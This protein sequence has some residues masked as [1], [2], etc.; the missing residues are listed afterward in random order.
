MDVGPHALHRIVS[1]IVAG[2][3]ERATASRAGRIGNLKPSNVLIGGRGDLAGADILLADPAAAS[4]AASMGEAGDRLSLGDVIHQLVLGRRFDDGTIWPLPPDPSWERLGD[5]GERW[6]RLCNDLL[7]PTPRPVAANVRSLA[8]VVQS[9]APRRRR[10]LLPAAAAALLLAVTVV[11]AYGYAGYR[12][13]RAYCEAK[14]QWLGA[15]A[16]AAADPA[17]RELYAR[18]AN[19]KK[20]LAELDRVPPASVDCHGKGGLPLSFTAF[21]RTRAAAASLATIT[22]ALS[23]EQWPALA[24]AASAQRRFR[25]RGWDQPA[26]YLARLVEGVRP[27]RSED[28][29]GGIDRFVLISDLEQTLGGIESDWKIVDEAQKTLAAS[30]VD[31]L[32]AFGR[33]LKADS[34]GAL[35][36]TAVGFEGTNVLARNAVLA[37]RAVAAIGRTKSGEIDVDR[38]AAD[39]GRK[40]DLANL[41]PADVE[42]W[43]AQLDAYRN[44]SDAVQPLVAQLRR[45]LAEVRA[46]VE[47]TRPDPSKKV[48]FERESAAVESGVAALAAKPIIEAEV[49]EGVLARQ[50]EELTAR[51]EALLKYRRPQSAA[52]WV[53]T[54]PD[55]ATTSTQVNEYWHGWRRVV[56]GR[57]TDVSDPAAARAFEAI[58]RETSRLHVQLD[59]LAKSFPPV[60]QGLSPA[61]A[62]AAGER[63][64]AAIGVALQSIRAGEGGPDPAVVQQSA[65]GYRAW[66]EQLQALAKDFPIREEL[67]D[68][69]DRPDQK[70]AKQTAFWRDP[71][72]RG[73]VEADVNRIER[74]QI[75]RQ[76]PRQ[77]LAQV[78]AED[79]E[80]EVVRA[81]WRLLGAAADAKQP[82]WPSRPGELDDEAR[83]SRRLRDLLRGVKDEKRRAAALAEVDAQAPLRWRTAVEHAT[84]EQT[85]ASA[86]ELRPAFGVDDAQH[87]RLTADAQFNLALYDARVRSRRPDAAA[88]AGGAEK[89]RGAVDA[90]KRAA[91]GLGGRGGSEDLL[92]KLGRLDAPEPFSDQQPGRNFRTIV[93]GA[94]LAF[95]RVEPRDARPFY[96]ATEELTIDQFARIVG[97]ATAWEQVQL[98]PWP[99]DAIGRTNGPGP[100]GWDWTGRRDAPITVSDYWLHPEEM[101]QYPPDF[102]VSRFNRTALKDEVGGNP[103]SGHPMHHVSP[104]V[105]LY[106]AGLAGCR[107]PTSR[108]WAAAYGVYERDVPVD[109]WNLRDQTWAQQQR[110]VA[111]LNPPAGRW[112]DAGA[113]VPPDAKPA[114]GAAAPAGQQTDGTLF[115]RP[116]AGPG[117]GT[118]R[119]LVGNVAEYVCDAPGRFD[120]LAGRQTAAAVKKF[121]ADVKDRIFVIGGS[122]LSP[123]DVPAGTPLPVGKTDRA[124]ADVG[125]RL[126]FTAPVPTLAERLR[127]VL[128]EQPYLWSPGGG[129]GGAA[130][131]AAA[132]P[133]PAAAAGAGAVPTP[134]A[135]GNGKVP[136]AEVAQ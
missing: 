90:L 29:V 71:A 22:D 25:S 62:A 123:P 79:T 31:V 85:L 67:L 26:D 75:L 40:G 44:K 41:K 18:R 82:P 99:Y 14:R 81:A 48:L 108:E 36:L 50:T 59:A 45:R 74:L 132:K 128:L 131:Q 127:W 64:E 42:A 49:R 10:R 66:S 9:L 122:A 76:L 100:R 16:E 109:R 24:R 88:A 33:V 112:P 102:L 1:G 105:A 15:F 17:R 111:T 78:A 83:L 96:L 98:L 35:R 7:A 58:K 93:R 8:K 20:V 91:T 72:V 3:V 63:R 106:V 30:G 116:A 136:S 27:G 86:I 51:V 133:R 110:H 34:A 107:L 124:Y 120:A 87:R 118:F 53:A 38:F 117:G 84:S 52:E 126:A 21:G 115:L 60:P 32:A 56:T 130:A 103:S 125:F 129:G 61:F 28:L 94:E 39:V 55:L 134:R 43:L 95:Q 12:S 2:L 5:K 6:R 37:E 11:A 47:S 57:V 65:A 4:L 13:Q 46:D 97:G 77:E 19:L 80:A 121:A 54:L 70:W 114:A 135:A 113:F 73:L 101:N 92:Y 119:H 104:E 68:L 23:A 69:D 89:L